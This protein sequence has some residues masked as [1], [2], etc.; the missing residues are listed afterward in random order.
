MGKTLYLEC[1]SGISGDM[2][3]ACLLDLGADWTKLESVLSTIP[4]KG[5][6]VKKSRV[7]KAGVDCMDFDVILDSEHENHD[8]DMEYLYGHDHGEDHH[9]DHDAHHHHHEENHHH[10]H[11][12]AHHHHHEED[13]HHDH[14]GHH[15][16]EEEHH[17]DHD[18]HHH[19]HHHEHR[20]LPEII[21]IIQNTKM[22]DNAKTIAVKIFDIVASAE[23][24][25][26]GVPKEQV[27][28]HEVGAIDSIVD[29]ISVAVCLEDLKITDVIVPKLCEGRGTV[30]CQH[31]ILPIPVPAVSNIISDHHLNI[32]L[33]SVKGE[34]ITPTGAAIVA[35][36]A[37]TD[38]L[39]ELMRIEKIGL[40][41]GKRNYE[42]PS[43]LRGM[44]ITDTEQKKDTVYKLESNIDDCTGEALGRTM[45]KLFDAGARDVNYHPVFMKKS[46]PGW[47]LNVICDEEHIEVLEKVI[48]EETTTI[49][50][51]RIKCERHILDRKIES[52]DTQYGSVEVK[53]CTLPDGK[54]RKY[55]E[56]ES[57]NDICERTGRPFVEIYNDILKEI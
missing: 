26:H 35:A 11:N 52:F 39:P 25:A 50:I 3:V 54:L 23:S 28:F 18:E 24:K 41:A 51:R 6:E 42:R 34:L 32:E 33:T 20:G 2:T 45:N 15:H 7:S 4:A 48:F 49:G 36:I 13:H 38:K 10:D 46:R 1:N 44:L 22:S 5:F 31:G 8:H 43:I 19:H 16:H 12:D 47:Q 55:P 27:H 30:R 40:G 56:Y 9:H 21:D 57:V 17:H 53:V 37:T 29:I 14:E